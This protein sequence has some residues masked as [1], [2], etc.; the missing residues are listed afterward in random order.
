VFFKA[1]EL[2]SDLHTSFPSSSIPSD[3]RKNF[4]PG[5]P[6]SA[7]TLISQCNSLRARDSADPGI[8]PLNNQIS[9]AIH[10]SSRQAW[11]DKVESSSH[12]VSSQKFWSLLKTL[13][14]K[15]TR[16]PPNQPISFKGKVQTKAP[17][18]S[19]NFCK[20]FSSVIP[21]DKTLGLGR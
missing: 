21:I 1:Q 7:K 14:G 4:I 3:F 11:A 5:L 18:I 12:R 2:E 9:E 6:N 13:S 15:S 16:P 10:V 20:T 17:T 8:L 19:K